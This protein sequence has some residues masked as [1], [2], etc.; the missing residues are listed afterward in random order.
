MVGVAVL[1]VVVGVAVE[2]P[3]RVDQL[4]EGE[5]S[6]SSI[7]VVMVVEVLFIELFAFQYAVTKKIKNSFSIVKYLL[8]IKSLLVIHP[9]K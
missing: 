5:G 9:K 8:I 6:S 1:V 4:A 3:H 7:V 2:D